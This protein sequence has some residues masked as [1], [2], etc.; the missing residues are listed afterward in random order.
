M[1]YGGVGDHFY[2]STLNINYLF[3]LKLRLIST[4]SNSSSKMNLPSSS[5]SAKSVTFSSIPD[6]VNH[7]TYPED[8]QDHE[9]WYSPEELE[10][11]LSAMFQDVMRQSHA[12][13]DVIANPQDIRAFE[14][15]LIDC[16]GIDHLVSRNVPRRIERVRQN[17]QEHVRRVLA[18]Q[19]RLREIRE[20]IEEDVAHTSEVSSR[21]NRV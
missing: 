3:H 19:T 17:G 7:I 18:A 14:Q 10:R 13:S 12:L 9:L 8:L 11:M 15:H 20:A 5:S 2:I 16:T 1:P 21:Q 6:E 4:K